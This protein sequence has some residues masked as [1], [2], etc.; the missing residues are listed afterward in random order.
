LAV[1]CQ[2][3]NSVLLRCNGQRATNERLGARWLIREYRLANAKRGPT[4]AKGFTVTDIV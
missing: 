4:G 3:V 2:Y 1:V